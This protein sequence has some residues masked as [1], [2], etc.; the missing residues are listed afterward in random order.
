MIS[1]ISKLICIKLFAFVDLFDY[2]KLSAYYF[3]DFRNVAIVKAYHPDS[4]QII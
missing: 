1:N 2:L 4:G 3:Y